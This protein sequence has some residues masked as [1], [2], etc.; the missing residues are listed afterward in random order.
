VCLARRGSQQALYL[1][2]QQNQ[3]VK[4]HTSAEH[5]LGMIATA[6]GDKHPAFPCENFK[7]RSEI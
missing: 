2:Q 1:A 5:N 3:Y 6:N 7:M 4:V